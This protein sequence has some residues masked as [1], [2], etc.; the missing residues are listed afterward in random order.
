[1]YKEIDE[2]NFTK[3]VESYRGYSKKEDKILE[4][5]VNLLDF[6]EPLYFFVDEYLNDRFSDEEIDIFY[7]NIGTGITPR[8]LLKMIT[9]GRK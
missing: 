9:E 1:M 7:H 2:K 8:K 6:V 4:L 5:G 3:A